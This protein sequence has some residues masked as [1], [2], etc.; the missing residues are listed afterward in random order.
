M[1]PFEPVDL[2]GWSALLLGMFGA[3]AAIGALRKPD[4][5]LTLVNEVE[6]SPAL[7]MLCG[8][9]ELLTGILVYLANPWL[10]GDILACL[11]KGLGG[12]MM[13]EALFVLGFSDLCF[14]FWLKNLAFQQ[15]G[16][17]IFSLIFG[18]AMMV[19]GGL[20]FH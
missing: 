11:M 18:L 5:W 20:R 1:Q 8:G 9:L 19:T 2:T 14:Q 6:R 17:A 13:L 15:R 10:P 3:F 4:H 16:W 7:Q 12:L